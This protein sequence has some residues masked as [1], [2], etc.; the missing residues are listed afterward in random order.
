MR[1]KKE[2]EGGRLKKDFI[3]MAQALNSTMVP[4][5]EENIEKYIEQLGQQKVR[6]KNQINRE[7]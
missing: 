5:K 4:E 3:K 1:E 2:E 7:M 6:T